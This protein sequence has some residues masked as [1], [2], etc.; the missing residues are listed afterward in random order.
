MTSGPAMS[1]M[2][3]KDEGSTFH[4]PTEDLWALLSPDRPSED[5]QPLAIVGWK[6]SFNENHY[7]SSPIPTMCL[8]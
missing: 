6:M 5:V 7:H 1:V 2:W 8:K 3:M 4:T